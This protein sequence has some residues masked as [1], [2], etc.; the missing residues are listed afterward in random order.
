M[1]AM[2]IGQAMNVECATG[3]VVVRDACRS[4]SIDQV[5]CCEP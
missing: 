3:I 2:R 4:N 5:S 1:Y